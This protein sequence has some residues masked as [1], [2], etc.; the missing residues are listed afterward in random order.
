LLFSILPFIFVWSGRDMTRQFFRDQ[1]RSCMMAT[2][3]CRR[4]DALPLG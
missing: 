3:L 4:S 2:E 1:C